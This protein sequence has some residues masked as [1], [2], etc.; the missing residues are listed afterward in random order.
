LTTFGEMAI[1]EWTLRQLD[2][3]PDCIKR[4]EKLKENTLCKKH[5]QE[6]EKKWQMLSEL[7][8]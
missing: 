2:E 1:E 4:T 5:E 6:Q 8:S 7:E 3:C